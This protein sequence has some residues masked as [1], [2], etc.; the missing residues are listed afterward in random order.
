M[1]SPHAAGLAALIESQYGRLKGGDVDLKPDRVAELMFGAAIDIG[2]PGYD[3]C[4]GHGRIDAL[5][6][7]TG[8]TSA[9]F[10]ATPFC[11]EYNE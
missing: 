5:R 11:P 6:A 4:F 9:A 3:E 1:A 7:V 10:L 2:L 8:D